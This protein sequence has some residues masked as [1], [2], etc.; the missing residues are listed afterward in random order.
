MCSTFISRC[1]SIT[2][3]ALISLLS[4]PQVHPLTPVQSAQSILLRIPTCL[5][6]LKFGDKQIARKGVP[7]RRVGGGTRYGA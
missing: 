5:N 1:S 3:L 7:G 2:L 6:S 4:C